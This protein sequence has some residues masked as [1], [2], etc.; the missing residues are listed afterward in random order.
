MRHLD[1]HREVGLAGVI[2]LTPGRRHSSNRQVLPECPSRV[3]SSAGVRTIAVSR[4]RCSVSVTSTSIGTR[5]VIECDWTSG[6]F[7]LARREALESAGFMDERFF[8]YSEEPD[9]CLRMKRAGWKVCHLPAMTIVHHAG[10]GGMRPKM[11]AQD[12]YTRMQHARKHFSPLHRRV[13]AAALGLGYAARAVAPVLRCIA[14]RPPDCSSRGA[15][16]DGR[17][18]AAAVRRAAEPGDPAP[19]TAG[20][21]MSDLLVSILIVNWNTRELVLECLGHC[22]SRGMAPPTRSSSSIM[23]PSTDP[24]RPSAAGRGSRSYETSATSASR[25]RSTRRTGA[26]AESS[27]SFSTPTST[28]SPPHSAP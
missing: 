25:P 12:A 21:T 6:S 26:R 13:Y 17:P 16:S 22:R 24:E 5:E 18:R 9:L 7:M 28:S 23:A 1:E 8:I 27:S 20:R 11:W 4:Y 2:Q 15:P 14:Q 3:R 10:K 19:S